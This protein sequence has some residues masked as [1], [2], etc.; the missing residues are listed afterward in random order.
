MLGGTRRRPESSQPRSFVTS[1]YRSSGVISGGSGAP[2]A[3]ASALTIRSMAASTRLRTSSSKVRTLSLRSASSGMMFSF[4][5]AWSAPIG[6]TALVRGNLP[7]DDR[8]QAQHCSGGHHH[9]IDA[10]LRHRAVGAPAE[11]PD[12]QAVRRPT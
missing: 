6:T 2:E 12:L 9:G 11:Q 8:L 1:A 5:P 3:A 7:R 4:V 10:G